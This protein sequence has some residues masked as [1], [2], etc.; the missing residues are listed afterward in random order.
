MTPAA[1]ERAFGDALKEMR[2]RRGAT[3]EDVARAVSVSRATIA[4]WEGGRHLPSGARARALDEY[5]TADGTLSALARQVREAGRADGAADAGPAGP[6]LLEV[7]RRVGDGLEHHLQRDAD[8][9]PLGWCQ[10]LQT[11]DPPTA[12]S[13]AYGI[14]ASLLI[15]ETGKADLAALSRHLRDMAL[16]GGGWGMS[17]QEES[18]PEATAVVVDALLRVDPTTDLTPRLALLER[19]VDDTARQRPALLATVLETVLDQRPASP[20][21]ADL[22]RSLLEIRRPRGPDD[23]PLWSQKTEPGLASPEPSTAHTARSV[24]VLARARSLGVDDQ[25]GDQ[26][27]EALG[28]AVPWL[29]HHAD[30]DNTS[31]PVSRR[32]GDRSEVVYIRHFTAAWVVRA[33]VLAGEPTTHPAVIGALRQ[34]QRYFSDDHALWR[35]NNGDLPVWMTF[36]AIATLRLA[37]LAAFTPH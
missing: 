22:I 1:T 12:M 35:W 4:Q 25:I 5:F 19:T 8:G 9:R 21:A 29:L 24:A 13:T 32:I 31:E 28:V 26:I 30:L 17:S 20:L 7:F 2:A 6:T 16:P 33:L 18:R 27:D 11:G 14:K 15:E 23:L 10:N 3:Q 36:D 37:A 34:V